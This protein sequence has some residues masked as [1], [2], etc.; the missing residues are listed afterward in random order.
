MFSRNSLSR[1]ENL[2]DYTIYSTCRDLRCLASRHVG[3]GSVGEGNR[4]VSQKKWNTTA[5]WEHSERNVKN[6]WIEA[7][8]KLK[9]STEHGPLFIRLV[10]VVR[11]KNEAAVAFEEML[12]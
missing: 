2:V 5:R 9:L 12:S 1:P 7:G 6:V 10:A 4:A 11:I 8:G 3:L